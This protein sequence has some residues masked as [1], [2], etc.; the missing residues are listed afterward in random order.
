MQAF[1]MATPTTNHIIIL[2]IPIQGR[3]T[4]YSCHLAGLK[5]K[6]RKGTKIQ[7]YHLTFLWSGAPGYSAIVL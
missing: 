6:T 7:F 5:D 2:P 3:L 4:L 1:Y